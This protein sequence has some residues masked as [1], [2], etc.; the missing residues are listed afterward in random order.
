MKVKKL[1][2]GMLLIAIFIT[3]INIIPFTNFVYA[4][5]TENVNNTKFHYQ[6]LN[7]TAKKIYDGIYEMYEQGILKTGTESF[8]LAK[9]NKYVTQE[10]RKSVV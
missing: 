8:D 10:D 6:Q 2:T 1:I 7:D 9:D 3:Q 4:Q 5:D